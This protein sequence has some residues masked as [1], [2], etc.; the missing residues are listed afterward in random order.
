MTH[1]PSSPSPE[2][3]HHSVGEPLRTNFYQFVRIEIGPAGMRLLKLNHP[4]LSIDIEN[5]D[6]CLSLHDAIDDATESLSEAI[7][8]ERWRDVIYRHDQRYRV[9]AFCEYAH[10][11]SDHAYWEILGDLY[12]NYQGDERLPDAFPEV[13]IFQH[14]LRSPRLGREHLMQAAD[15]DTFKRLPESFTVYRGFSRGDGSGISWTIDRRVAVFFAGLEMGRCDEGCT[16]PPKVLT[17]QV[18]NKS[19]IYAY[20]AKESE[21]LVPMDALQVIGMEEASD[22]PSTHPDERDFDFE[23]W[24]TA[25]A[26]QPS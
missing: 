25:S 22:G 6:D 24:R 16:L 21:V 18:R 17:A 13:L 15:W 7:E 1:I 9:R 8:E 19:L 3:E 26:Q 10:L 11:L 2:D 20:F 23:A 4:L 14:L 12:R 5:F